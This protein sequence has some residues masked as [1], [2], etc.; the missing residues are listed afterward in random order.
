MYL[1]SL[2]QCFFSYF[3]IYSS[4]FF[5][6]MTVSIFGGE[7]PCLSLSSGF[8][9][10][11]EGASLSSFSLDLKKHQRE[12]ETRNIYVGFRPGSTTN[13]SHCYLGL[14][15]FSQRHKKSFFP[16]FFVTVHLLFIFC[17][18]DACFKKGI[19]HYVSMKN[20]RK[21]YVSF[22]GSSARKAKDFFWM[23]AF[24]YFFGWCGLVL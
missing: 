6:W 23:G 13:S 14:F 19:T 12:K 11:E 7:K 24:K 3:I 1:F 16:S 22:L 10:N 18:L 15:S 8:T 21:Y 17:L 2:F 5:R 20:S 9:W 4:D